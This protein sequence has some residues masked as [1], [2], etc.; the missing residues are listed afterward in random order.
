MS[1]ATHA[2][3]GAVPIGTYV[4]EVGASTPSYATFQPDREDHNVK[5][6]RHAL[7]GAP[8][9]PHAGV[10]ALEQ[11]QQSA[12]AVTAKCERA[13]ELVRAVAEGRLTETSALTAEIDVLLELAERLDRDGRFDEELRLL[14][15]LYGLGLLLRRWLDLVRALRR[16]LSAAEKVGD[17]AEQAWVQHELGSLHLCADQPEA[18]AA[19]LREAFRLQQSMGLATGTCATRHNLDSATRDTAAPVPSTPWPRRMRRLAGIAGVVTVVAVGGATL[20]LAQSD[21]SP[22]ASEARVSTSTTDVTTAPTTTTSEAS[23]GATPGAGTPSDPGTNPADDTTPPVVVLS[24]PQ[25]GSTTSTRTPLFSGTGGVDSGDAAEVFVDIEDSNGEP[26]DGS[27]LEAT[28]VD[29]TWSVTPTLGLS[30]GT[31]R[32]TARQ[33]DSAGNTGSSATVTFTVDTTPLDVTNTTPP[34]T[35]DTTTP[36]TTDP[37]PPDTPDPPPDVP[38]PP[39]DTPDPPPPDTPAPPPPEVTDPAP[40]DTPDPTPPSID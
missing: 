17:V 36:N 23:G 24:T 34:D 5:A 21:D 39:P 20:A 37:P 22:S 19:H 3:T 11:V 8:D 18:A 33:S 16:G 28:L 27:P 25:D 40:P 9:E 38:D 30:D 15:A 32:A 29:N 1:T 10:A 12:A 31:Y 35:T 7:T 26:L 4:L 6:L 2:A 13:N 14:R